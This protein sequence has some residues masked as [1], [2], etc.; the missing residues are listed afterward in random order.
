MAAA[1][2]YDRHV[3]RYGTQLAPGLIE[4]AGVK[5][6]DRV[7]DVGCGTG[8]L[9][10]ELAAVVG[11][12]NVSA[13]DPSAAM[14]EVARAR[15][16]RA[17]IRRGSAEA[18]PFADSEF[19]AA[20]AQLVINLV[21]DPPQAVREMARVVRPGGSVAACFWHDEAMPLLRSFWDSIRAVAPAAFAEVDEH[22]Q[23]GVAE[24]EQL[25]RWWEDAGLENVE[26][27]DFQ[28]AA[29]YEDFNDLFFAF[30]AGVGHSGGLY[31]ALEADQRSAVR[32]DV[33]QR[34]GAT[35]A[36]FRLVATVEWVR[37]LR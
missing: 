30:E 2:P 25:R 7:L 6:G 22:A 8:Q 27:G 13:L 15:V 21:E 31:L 5:P 36:R 10:I 32:A 29:E 24:T 9:T 35:D 18:L 33:R 14:L 20:L 11:E 26:L 34:L 1:H 28:V 4:V 19:D 3:G 16:P 17:D 12:E 37:G 23:V